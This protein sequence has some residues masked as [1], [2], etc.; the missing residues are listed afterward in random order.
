MAST[1]CFLNSAVSRGTE[2][3]V[4]DGEVPESEHARMRAPFQ[5]GEF[6]TP[7]K[8]GYASVGVVEDGPPELRGRAVFCLYPHQTR[9]VV[10]QG[11]LF[12]IMEAATREFAQRHPVP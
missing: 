5:D 10:P 2:L 6:P 11:A 1:P 7:V 8:Y 4:F 3:L 12:L 9:Y